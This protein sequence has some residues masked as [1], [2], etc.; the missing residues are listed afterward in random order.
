MN[1]QIM[2]KDGL[3]SIHEAAILE[4]KTGLVGRVLKVHVLTPALQID[5]SVCTQ[6]AVVPR[7]YPTSSTACSL[8]AALLCWSMTTEKIMGPQLEQILL[9]K[10]LAQGDC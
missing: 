4:L 1:F 3:N 8:I 5:T 6:A 10:Y 7:L 2:P 9:M